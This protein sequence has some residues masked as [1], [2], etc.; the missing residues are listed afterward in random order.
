MPD[1]NGYEVCEALRAEPSLRQVPV[2]LLTGTFEAFDQ[3]RAVAVGANDHVTKPFESQVLI[4]K[5]KQLLFARGL[6]S[7]APGRPL[8]VPATL[9]VPELSLEST[10]APP[11][12][13]PRPSELSTPSLEISQDQLWQLLEGPPQTPAPPVELSLESL[14]SPRPSAAP[15]MSLADVSGLELSLGSEEPTPVPPPS[16]GPEEAAALPDLSLDDLLAGAAPSPEGPAAAEP[17]FDLT[18]AMEAPPLSMVEAGRG[19]PPS[20]SMEE[21]LGTEEPAAPPTLEPPVFDLSELEPVA[22]ET[23]LEEAP[24]V[25]EP[26][27]EPE[28]LDLGLDLDLSVPAAAATPG[29][30]ALEEISEISEPTGVTEL[31][32][33]EEEPAAPPTLEPPGFDLSEL[34]P[35]VVEVSLTPA[36]EPGPAEL[37]LGE[38]AESPALPAD[39]PR[40]PDLAALRDSV[41]ER[42]ASDLARELSGTL[43]ARIEKVVWEVVPDLAEVLIAREIERIRRMAEEQ[44]SA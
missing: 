22:L 17:V 38:P 27:D 18:A 36:A 39:V 11:P 14:E 1:K 42:V 20:F 25:A 3:E 31:A 8:S 4:G 7:A 15:E 24:S 44:K 21:L 28:A 5:I 9:S 2:I 6:D 41:T 30:L 33:M 12:T 10:D 40:V 29:A 23:V 19:E 16:P 43:I 37:A 34:E 32:S 13:A 35:P 26:L